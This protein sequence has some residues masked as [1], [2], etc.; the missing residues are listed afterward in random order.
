[1]ASAGFGAS[2]MLCPPEAEDDTDVAEEEDDDDD[3]AVDGRTVAA[4]RDP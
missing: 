1:M 4:V 2:V 3:D